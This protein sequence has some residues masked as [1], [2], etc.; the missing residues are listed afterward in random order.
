MRIRG[1]L[2]LL[3]LP[4][5]ALDLPGEIQGRGNLA[6][7][8]NERFLVLRARVGN[9]FV[10]RRSDASGVGWALAAMAPAA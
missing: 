2:K 7:F 9:L 5:R 1:L 3:D 8:C 10:Q 6:S 4:H